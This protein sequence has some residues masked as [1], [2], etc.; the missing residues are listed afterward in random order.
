MNGLLLR[1]EKQRIYR[2]AFFPALAQIRRTSGSPVQAVKPPSTTNDAPVIKDASS[3]A[4]NS[5]VLAISSA[6]PIRPSGCAAPWTRRKSSA[7]SLPRSSGA[8]VLIAPGQTQFTLMLCFAFSS[9]AERVRLIT[10]A[11]AALYD[12]IPQSPRVPEID[13]VLTIA[14]PPC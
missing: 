5:T 13:A 4:R 14:P 10:P 7:R 8:R 12:D 6:S 11:L 9:A 3:E 1:T 2:A